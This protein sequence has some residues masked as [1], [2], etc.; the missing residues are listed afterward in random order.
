MILTSDDPLFKQCSISVMDNIADPT[1]TFD[2]DGICN[3]YYRYKQSEAQST[4]T[5]EAGENKIKDIVSKIKNKGKNRKY[6]CIIGVSGGIDSTYLSL[7]AKEYGLRVLCVHFDNGWDSQ[8][9][10]SNI[11]NIVTKCGFDL[12]TYVIDW[13]EFRDIQLSYFKAGV[14]DIEAANDI[15]IFESLDIICAEKGIGYI[16]DGRN[17]WT[18]ET[19]PYVWINKNPNNLYD[20]HQKF[21]KM[22]LDKF[23]A[24]FKNGNHIKPKGSFESIP[25]LNY[26]EY[27]KKKTKEIISKELGWL[28]Y[29]GKHYESVFTRFYQGYILPEKFGVD[30]RK[31]HL[32]NLIFSG[33]ISKEEAL[34]ELKRPAYSPAQLEIDKV[35]VLKKLGF[36][37]EEFEIYMRSPGVPH[38]FYK[39]HSDVYRSPL[40]KIRHALG[41]IKR[42]FK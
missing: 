30:K 38:E 28:D 15:A 24:R 10:V 3:Y 13:D 40:L 5:G 14:I 25:L 26:M 34:D 2:K 17:V 27:N 20:I 29:G 12:F 36:S 41:K 6:D 42:S 39:N 1:I 4:L 11:Q 33:Q 7:K 22:R 16:L 35:Y 9:A 21:G 32:S 31:S 8:E 37:E 18:E 19:L 23:P